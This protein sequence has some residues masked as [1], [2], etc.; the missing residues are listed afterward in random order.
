MKRFHCCLALFAGASLLLTSCGKSAP[1]SAPAVATQPPAAAKPKELIVGKW[2]GK[3]SEKLEFAPDGAISLDSSGFQNNGKYKFVDDDTL[4]YEWKT[5]LG[6][7][8]NVKCKVKVSKDELALDIVDVKS[9]MDES[10]QWQHE[11]NDK[12]RMGQTEKYK[13]LP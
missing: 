12:A 3:E 5:A 7:F 8:E 9:R 1:S 13:R 10:A 4:E 2:Q 6:R 11:A